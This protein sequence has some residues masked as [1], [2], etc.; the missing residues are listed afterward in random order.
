MRNFHLSLIHDM[1]HQLWP[2]VSK[3]VPQR[4]S[5]MSSS[6]LTLQPSSVRP[7]VGLRRAGARAGKTV[8]VSFGQGEGRLRRAE[9]AVG[10]GMRA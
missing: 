2:W 5:W 10:R 1:M 7:V 8:A 4:F 9:S 6:S 3:P